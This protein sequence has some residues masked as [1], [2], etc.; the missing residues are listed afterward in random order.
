M[1][2]KSE[3]NTTCLYSENPIK[4]TP[5]K[6]LKFRKSQLQLATGR[7]SFQCFHIFQQII[8]S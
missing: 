5:R 4:R 3:K 6:C 7:L 1:N 2:A 8:K